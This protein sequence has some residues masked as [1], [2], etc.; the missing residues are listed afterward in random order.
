MSHDL[1]TKKGNFL[2]RQFSSLKNKKI[3][4]KKEILMDYVI[5]QISFLGNSAVQ[6]VT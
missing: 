6:K 1:L 4:P 3:L 5:N 2:K